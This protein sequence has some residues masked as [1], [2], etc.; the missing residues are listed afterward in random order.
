[1]SRHQ[2]TAMGAVAVHEE[3]LE[4][5]AEKP[6]LPSRKDDDGWRSNW[7]NEAMALM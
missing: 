6:V 3:Q 2:S 4:G 5:F 7:T 1:V